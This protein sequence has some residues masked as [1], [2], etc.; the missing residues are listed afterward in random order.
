MSQKSFDEL[1]QECLDKCLLRG[2][3]HHLRDNTVREYFSNGSFID[4]VERIEIQF[5][6]HPI[7]WYDGG[8]YNE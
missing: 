4:A 7:P 3:S 5:E 2:H 6:V 8:E 1:M